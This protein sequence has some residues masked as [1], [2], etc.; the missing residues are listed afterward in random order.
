[1]GCP[2]LQRIK[3]FGGESIRVLNQV[4]NWFGLVSS[5]G[6]GSNAVPSLP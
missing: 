1:M 6:T 4:G 2:K 5:S 3:V